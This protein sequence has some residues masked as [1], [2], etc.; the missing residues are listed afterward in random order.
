MFFKR[1]GFKGDFLI[2]DLGNLLDM[3]LSDRENTRGWEQEEIT[4]IQFVVV[5]VEMP[6]RYS[7]GEKQPAQILHKNNQRYR[8]NIGVC[9]VMETK[10]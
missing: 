8:I 1:K 2:F 10:R 7:S 6:E 3:P 4:F 5:V 9:G